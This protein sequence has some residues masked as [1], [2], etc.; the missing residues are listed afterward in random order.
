MRKIAVFVAVWWVLALMPSMVQ[1]EWRGEIFL[2]KIPPKEVRGVY[3]NDVKFQE[4]RRKK[5]TIFRTGDPIYL[6]L[7]FEPEGNRRI[8]FEW[9]Q[10]GVGRYETGHELQY[11]PGEEYFSWAHL[12]TSSSMKDSLQGSKFAGAWTVIVKIDGKKIAEA[13]FEI[14]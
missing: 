9:Y 12:S 14:K 1:A 3:L 4:F 8:D 13:S 7:H 10:Y 5:T 2:A 6:F 11:R